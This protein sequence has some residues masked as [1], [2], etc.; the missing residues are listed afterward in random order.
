MASQ[1]SVRV[2]SRIPQVAAKIIVSA[3]ATEKKAALLTAERARALAPVDSG[4]LRD[5]ITSDGN[6]AQSEAEYS[7]LVN[8]GTR[9]TPANPFWSRALHAGVIEFVKENVE[10]LLRAK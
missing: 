2:F 4:Y 8:Y 5:H 1:S 9:D 6:K 3:E 10:I 7:R